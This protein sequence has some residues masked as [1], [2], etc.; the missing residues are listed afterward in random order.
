MVPVKAGISEGCPIRQRPKYP[1]AHMPNVDP[2]LAVTL[3]LPSHVTVWAHGKWRPGWLIGRSH[4]STGWFGIVQY[5]DD[6]GTEITEPV[7]AEQIA[8]ADTWLSD[9]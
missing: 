2:R 9:A 1:K 8:A 6:A 4:E 7:A 5:D 3:P